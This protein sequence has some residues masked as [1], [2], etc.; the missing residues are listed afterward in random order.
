[1]R[2]TITSPIRR[3]T[4]L[5]IVTVSTGLGLGLGPNASAQNQLNETGGGPAQGAAAEAQQATQD[6]SGQAQL[7]QVVVTA[8]RRPEPLQSVPVAVVVVTPKQLQ[9]NLVT[10]LPNLAELAPQAMIGTF[11]SGTGAVISMRGIST[12]PSDSGLDQSV[13]TVIDGVPLSR[14]R[15]IASSLFDMSQVEIM[16]GPQTLFFGKNSPAGVIDM[17]TADPTADLEGNLSAGYEFNAEERFVQ[18]AISG[19]LTSGV[20]GRLAFRYDDMEG[21]LT[22]VATPTADPFQPGVTMPGAVNGGTSPQSRDAAGRLSLVANPWGDFQASLKVTIDQQR[23]NSGAADIDT[24]CTGG[25]T[26][27]EELGVPLPNGQCQKNEL[28]DQSALPAQYGINYPNGNGGVP[29]STSKFS[30]SSLNLNDKIDAITLASTTGFYNQT[31]ADSYNADFTPFTQIF[32]AE[33]E[34]YNLFTQELRMNSGFDGPVN[35]MGGLYYEHSLRHWQNAPDIFNFYDPI[36]NNYI[37]NWANSESHN[38]SFSGFGELRWDITQKLQFAAGARYTHDDKATTFTNLINNPDS[39]VAA[40]LYPQGQDLPIH[41]RGSNVSPQATLSW[42]P[43]QASTVYLA[44]KTGYKS[45]G[46]S[47]PA[48]LEATATSQTLTFGAERTHGFEAGYKADLLSQ[49]L[50]VGITVYRYNYD[51]L[52]VSF[53]NAPTLSYLVGN[54]AAS[55]TKGVQGS[56]EWL[57][58]RSLHFHG[59][60]GYNS[61]R[62]V[63][64]ANAECY[65]GQTAGLG[66]VNGVQNLSG[67]APVDAPNLTFNLGADYDVNLVSGWTG[68]FA[69]DGTHTSSYQTNADN[70]PG[71]IQ[72]AYWKL[73]ASVNVRTP[74]GRLEF[75]LIGRDLNNAYY[76]V[77]S[78]EQPGVGNNNQF[79][80]FFNRPREIVLQ[81]EYRF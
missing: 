20:D 77:N 68:D 58:T 78:T 8:E 13:V 33:Y 63:S 40:G 42:H 54:A 24:Y 73:N 18:G 75:S 70:N 60:L 2:D 4:A 29:Y 19:P 56:F 10:D 30:L 5:L 31:I 51:G 55:L 34:N 80:A 74:D 9:S 50:R 62:F 23:L 22:N 45:G 25:E 21:W 12:L 3:I 69:V 49:T 11:S 27:P 43:V 72:S 81:A 64:F 53:F 39:P 36:G 52:Q 15:I 28:I 1:M 38:Q 79:A 26:V 48:L 17:H 71:G 16:E 76:M 61:A 57:A 59:N 35:F 41:Y 14:G 46:I 47:N 6:T 65:P 44:Y 67:Q 37:A 32:N 7:Q 66:C